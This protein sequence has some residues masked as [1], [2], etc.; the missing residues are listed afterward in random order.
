MSAL[1]IV[2]CKLSEKIALKPVV[3]FQRQSKFLYLSRLKI[4][5]NFRR[6]NEHN[7]A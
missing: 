1:I 6:K 4:N 2:K 5:L 7:E 3:F